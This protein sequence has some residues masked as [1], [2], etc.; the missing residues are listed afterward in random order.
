MPCSPCKAKK[1]LRLEKAKVISRL[2]FTIKLLEGCSG[3]KQ[4]VSL[5]IDSGSK[6]IG[7]AAVRED[8]KTLYASETTLR[9]N[10]HLKMEK[11]ASYRRTRRSRKTRYRAARFNNRKRNDGWLTPTMTSKVHAHEQE[12]KFVRSR[13]PIQELVI[14][15]ASFDIHKITNSEVTK[16]TY[17]EGRQ[18]GFY[19]VKAFVLARDEH[20]CQ[21]CKQGKSGTKLHNHHIVF[22]CNGGTDSPD[23]LITLCLDCHEQLH[24]YSDAQKRSLK[25]QKKKCV[26]TSDAVQVSTI[27][28]YLRQRLNFREVFGYETKF[29]REQ[30][31][32]P[33]S[34]FVDAMCAGAP[35]GQRIK[36]PEHVF[37]KKRVPCGDY[38]QTKAK[39]KNGVRPRITRGKICGFLRYDRVLY[40]GIVAF[41]EGRMSTGYTKLTDIFGE[42][43]DFGHIPKFVNMK[44][45]GA[46]KSCLIQQTHIES[47]TSST[48]SYSSVNIEK[49][50]SR[51]KKL[52]SV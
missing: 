47:F 30:L 36:M 13:L 42:F 49:S 10:I 29:D 2:P 51:V 14:E 39:H 1:L 45:I 18:K 9:N 23:N 37:Q 19:N 22:R 24:A 6:V 44:R 7:C 25:L 20:T 8:G 16:E 52:P 12:I 41:I 43:L 33:K 32:L 4:P 31:G 28:A 46:R 3:Y 26:N 48:I 35:P 17:Q 11:R 27:G 40:R 15:T 50:C 21:I 34:H 38:A 5:R